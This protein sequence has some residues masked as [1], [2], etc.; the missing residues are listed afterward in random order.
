MESQAVGL[1]TVAY[2]RPADVT[3]QLNGLDLTREVLLEAVH[4][5][6]TYAAECTRHDPSSLAGTLLWGKTVRHLRDRLIPAGWDARDKRNL[7]LTVH[8]SGRWAIVVASGDEHTGIPD[9]TPS[10]RY[11]R[12]SATQQVVSINQLSF[13]TLSADFAKLD[14][15]ALHRT[16]FLLHYR[17][18]DADE[19]RVELSL[20]IEMTSDNFVTQWERRIILAGAGDGSASAHSVPDSSF[21]PDVD[22]IDVPVLKRA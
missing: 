15:A 20:P 11:D 4:F 12:G 5:G 8:P 10:T 22:M 3:A 17:D 7:P 6:S 18:N 14:A 16:W 9:R 1:T 21:D 2:V 19:I 13:A